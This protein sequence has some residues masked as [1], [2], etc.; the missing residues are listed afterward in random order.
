MTLLASNP[1]SRRETS[2]VY[3]GNGDIYMNPDGFPYGQGQA[4]FTPT[5]EPRWPSGVNGHG[6]PYVAEPHRR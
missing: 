1:W 6:N 2:V 4:P 3:A 5:V